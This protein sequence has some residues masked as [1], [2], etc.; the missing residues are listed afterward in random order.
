[1]TLHN[2]VA[3]ITGA[4]G[5]IGKAIAFELLNNNTKV[6]IVGRNITKVNKVKEDIGGSDSSVL[7]IEYNLSELENLKSLVN[8]VVSKFGKLDFLINSAGTYSKTKEPSSCDLKE[9]D[10]TLDINFR[11]VY[12]LCR[13]SIGYIKKQKEGAIINIGSLAA[14]FT[15]KNGEMYC[16]SKHALLAY[17]KCLFENLRE[18]N[19]KVCCINPGFVNTKMGRED[20]LISE[21]MIQPEDVAIMVRDILASA[22]TL[23][24]IEINLKPQ[25]SPYR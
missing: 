7:S 15:Y 24:P 17:S 25:V 21:K 10:N 18:D 20:N 13:Y 11:S 1:M 16:P 12:H 19:I 9:W 22:N 2:K 3:L 5:G 6:A 14:T 23:N 8:K 4:T